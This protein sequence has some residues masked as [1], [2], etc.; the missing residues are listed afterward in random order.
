MT[1][2]PIAIQTVVG[3]VLKRILQEPPNILQSLWTVQE[4]VGYVPPGTIG[5]IARHVGVTD[6]DVAGV[7]AFYPGLHTWPCGRD[8]AALPSWNEIR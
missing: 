6:A 5:D 2:T 1:E 8:K 3:D 4:A 7:F